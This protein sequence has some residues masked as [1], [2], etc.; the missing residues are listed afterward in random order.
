M[1]FW[2][3]DKTI[4]KYKNL[5][6]EKKNCFENLWGGGQLPPCIHP[7]PPLRTALCTYGQE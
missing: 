3:T 5:S 6:E 1:I 2:L 7:P 4:W